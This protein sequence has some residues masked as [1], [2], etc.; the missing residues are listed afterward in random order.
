VTRI[1]VRWGGLSWAGLLGW[2]KAG[3]W[4]VIEVGPAGF[5]GVVLPLILARRAVSA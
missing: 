5:P 4:I 1:S 3:L 2:Q